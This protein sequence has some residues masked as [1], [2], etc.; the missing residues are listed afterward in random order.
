MNWATSEARNDLEGCSGAVR[1]FDAVHVH[2]VGVVA[3]TQRLT[4]GVSIVVVLRTY[5]IRDTW[6]QARTCG[7]SGVPVVPV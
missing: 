4:A 5:R 6:Y 3:V 2:V 7:T 1:L